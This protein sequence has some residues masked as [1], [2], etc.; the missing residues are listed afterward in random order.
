M[1]FK[2]D[3][4]Y[5]LDDDEFC[6]DEKQMFLYLVLFFHLLFIIAVTIIILIE[7]KCISYMPQNRS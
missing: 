5:E 6:I 2:N 3:V 7:H 1:G 4:E